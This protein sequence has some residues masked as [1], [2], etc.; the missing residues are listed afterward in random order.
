MQCPK[1]KGACHRDSVDIGVGVIH[2]PF[3]CEE[4][5]WS[6]NEKY[7]LS[8][9]KNPV[10]EKGGAIDQYGGYHPLGSNMALAYKLARQK[11]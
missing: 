9:G 2:G 3:G 6:E 7:D 11:E 8:T 4:C 10:D 1:C 5:G